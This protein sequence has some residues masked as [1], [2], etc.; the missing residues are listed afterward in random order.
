MIGAVVRT[1][2]NAVI[3][4]VPWHSSTLDEVRER[5]KVREKGSDLVTA[6]WVWIEGWCCANSNIAW[7]SRTIWV[8][9]WNLRWIMELDLQH[10]AQACRA[11][12]LHQMEQAR[13][14]G[15][16]HGSSPDVATLDVIYYALYLMIQEKQGNL[17]IRRKRIYLMNLAGMNVENVLE[18]APDFVKK[19]KHIWNISK[20]HL[21]RLQYQGTT[22]STDLLWLRKLA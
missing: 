2:H 14:N 3:F 12:G 7:L 18:F 22:S 4:Y 13:L 8:G 5:E 10:V 9:S 1:L 6:N 16:Y 19:R 20:F 15:Q 17:I 21:S 11:S